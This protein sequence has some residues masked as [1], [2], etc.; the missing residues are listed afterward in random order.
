M[1]ARTQPLDGHVPLYRRPIRGQ[2][3]DPVADQASA[4]TG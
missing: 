4:L 3:G 1:V 2:A